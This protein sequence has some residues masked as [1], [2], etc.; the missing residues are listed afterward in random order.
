MF[1]IVFVLIFTNAFVTEC[2]TLTLHNITNNSYENV[3]F[4]LYENITVNQAVSWKNT[5]TTIKCQGMS[6]LTFIR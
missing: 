4:E 3:A 1:L 5:N 6:S 2:L